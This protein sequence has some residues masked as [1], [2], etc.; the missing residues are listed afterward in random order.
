[1]LIKTLSKIR[2]YFEKQQIGTT[3]ALGMTREC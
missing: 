1:M 2:P 3:I